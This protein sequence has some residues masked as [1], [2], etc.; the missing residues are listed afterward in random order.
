VPSGNDV[1]SAF[2]WDGSWQAHLSDQP[3]SGL[4]P[5][6][7]ARTDRGHCQVIS[8]TGPVHAPLGPGLRPEPITG[9]WVLLDPDDRVVAVLPRRTSLTRGAGRTDTR[10]QLLAA[11]VDLV[12][13]VQPLSSGPVLG[14]I[15]RMLALAWSSGAQPLVLLTKADLSPDPEGER[16]EVAAAA[17]GADVLLVSAVDGRGLD[18]LRAILPAGATG[19]LL[20]PSGAGKSSLINALVGEDILLTRDIRDDGKGRHTSVARE[21]V[22]LPWGALLIDTPG[23]RGV[24]LWDADEGLDRTFADLEELATSCRFHDCGHASE[25]GCAVQAAIAGGALTA[26]RLESWRKLRREQEWLASRY[27]AR[28]RAE[29]RRKWKTLSK[30]YKQRGGRP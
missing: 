1:L 18:E 30:M 4:R 11:N 28:L 19:V 3:D 12:A 6:R 9:D 24:Q 26:R 5:A 8:A 20:G 14:R 2:G 29:Q 13:C 27:D 7:V 16:D 15:E 21:L 17:P 23:L 22:P 10:G 25:P